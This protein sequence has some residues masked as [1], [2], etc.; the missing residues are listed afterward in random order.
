MTRG[1]QHITTGVRSRASKEYTAGAAPDNAPPAAHTPQRG[2]SHHVS[3]QG[4]IPAAV[5]ASGVAIQAITPHPA[6]QQ[7]IANAQQH[8]AAARARLLQRTQIANVQRGLMAAGHNPGSTNGELDYQTRAALRS[9][10]ANHHLPV[11][12][13]VDGATHAAVTGGA[14][15]T[16]TGKRAGR[17]D[18]PGA[19]PNVGAINHAATKGA[20][21]VRLATHLPPI[22]PHRVPV[23]GVVHPSHPAPPRSSFGPQKPTPPAHFR[24]SFPGHLGSTPGHARFPPHQVSFPPRGAQHAGPSSGAQQGLKSPPGGAAYAGPSGPPQG[25]GASPPTSQ[26]VG[27]SG[28]QG[29]GPGGAA[30]GDTGGRHGGFRPGGS[31][32]RKAQGGMASAQTQGSTHMANKGNTKGWRSTGWRI[33]LVLTATITGGSNAA[34]SV[35][36]QMDFRGENLVIDTTTVGPSSTLTIPSI[37]TIPQIAGGTAS[38]AVP[39]TLFSPAQAGA[40]D[41]KMSIANQG[42]AVSFTANNTNTTVTLS[43]A[44]LLFGTEVEMDQSGGMTAGVAPAGAYTGG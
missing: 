39:G 28:G 32:G 6:V 27:F 26:A 29:H 38:T 44:A 24:N 43:F 4:A 22:H 19:H 11:T 33:C 8:P 1:P 3:T 35:N 10:Q 36:P 9:F 31:A 17:S 15:E 7:A 13:T 5:S 40:L 18:L 41:F 23:A 30:A 12:G 16:G 37:G 2:A 14:S 20:P 25:A 42:N 21:V 34:I